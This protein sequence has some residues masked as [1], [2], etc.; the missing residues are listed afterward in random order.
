MVVKTIRLEEDQV[1]WIDEKSINLS[2][3]VRKKIIEEME[4]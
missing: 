4:K 2:K 1:K 3:F